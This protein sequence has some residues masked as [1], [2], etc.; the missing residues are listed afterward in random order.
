MFFFD[1]LG[2]CFILLAGGF[3]LVRIDQPDD[4]FVFELVEPEFF[5]F[6]LQNEFFS[7][8]FRLQLF[9]LPFEG[10][11]FLVAFLLDMGSLSF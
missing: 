5:L 9:P 10:P 8:E 4:L 2:F 3:I 7:F 6:F 1:L 11:Y